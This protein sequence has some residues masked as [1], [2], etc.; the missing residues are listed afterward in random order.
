MI[1]HQKEKVTLENKA[2]IINHYLLLVNAKSNQRGH[3][4]FRLK[5]LSLKHRETDESLG[6]SVY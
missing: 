1:A 2:K 5:P 4:P 6:I 3:R